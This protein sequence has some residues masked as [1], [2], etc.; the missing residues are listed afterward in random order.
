MSENL[1]KDPIKSE[2]RRRNQAYQSLDYMLSRITYFDFFS[3]D[4]FNIAKSSKAF[5]QFFE[6]QTVT[7]EFLLLS[8]FYCDSNL[9]C[10]LDEFELKHKFLKI[11]NQ[12]FSFNQLSR[13]TFNSSNFDV[14]ENFPYSMEVNLLFEKAAENALIRFK[15]PVITSE[16]L[17][18]TL[19]EL[20]ETKVGKL[21]QK[22]ILTETEW[23]LLRYRLV[24][25]LHNNESII[26]SEVV[27]NQQYFAYLLKT[28]LTES[29]F[30]KLVETT[31]LVEGVQLF[32]NM[33]ISELTKVNVFEL[34]SDEIK[35]SI[36]VTNNRKYSS[37]I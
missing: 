28:E 13:K 34:I 14:N 1:F 33:L 12:K 36:K 3:Y 25:S 18:L 26:K 37:N 10:L 23:H 22:Q 24:K 8:F 31:S 4:A 2:R 32:R 27:K 20:T 21:I 19:M 35:K 6:K 9:L 11:L 15:T 5:T 30:N 17:F 16:I 7:S 29:E